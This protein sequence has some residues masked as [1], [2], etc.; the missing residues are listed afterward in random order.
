[1]IEAGKLTSRVTFQRPVTVAGEGTT[2]YSDVCTVWC[3]D[4]QLSGN[5]L[6]DAMQANSKVT[7]NIHIRYRRDV[8]SY[9]RMSI[10]ARYLKINS[11]INKNN[12]NEMLILPYEEWID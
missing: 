10:G 8:Q 7:G 9:M 11:I 5:K 2:S 4:E 12:A 6:F 1:M 3:W